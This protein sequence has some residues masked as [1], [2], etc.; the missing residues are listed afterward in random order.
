MLRTIDHVNRELGAATVLITH[1]VA[2]ADMADR[3][4]RMTSGKISE[5]YRNARRISPEELAW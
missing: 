2:I 1:N 5:E 4:L 3:V